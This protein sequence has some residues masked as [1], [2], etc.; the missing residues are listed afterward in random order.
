M[1]KKIVGRTGQPNLEIVCARAFKYF[2]SAPGFEQIPLLN[3]IATGK[4]KKHYAHQLEEAKVDLSNFLNNMD[5]RVVGRLIDI[6]NE[7]GVTLPYWIKNKSFVIDYNH[8]E[9]L[10]LIRVD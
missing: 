3:T 6:L 4:L 10:D 5:I 1:C 7:N 2:I 9:M 8:R